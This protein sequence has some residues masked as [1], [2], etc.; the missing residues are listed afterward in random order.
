MKRSHEPLHLGKPSFAHW[1]ITDI[2]TNLI[3]IIIFFD[4]AFEYG[5]ISKFWGYV[6]TDARLLLYKNL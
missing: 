4:G 6:G 1:K 5:G 2:T 3:W